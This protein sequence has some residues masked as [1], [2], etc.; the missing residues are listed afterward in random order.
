MSGIGTAV[1]GALPAIGGGLLGTAVAGP[2]GGIVGAAIAKELTKPGGL[3]SGLKNIDTSAIGS[4]VNGGQTFTFG[5]TTAFAKPQSGGKYDKFPDAPSGGYGS[6][7][8][9]GASYS[10]RDRDRMNS[11]SPGASRAIGQGKGGLY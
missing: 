5:P 10:N 1:K 2:L 4:I 7:G 3:M 11:I 6:G 9:M 8:S